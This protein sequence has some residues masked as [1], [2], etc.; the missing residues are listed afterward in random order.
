MRRFD[1]KRRLC[2]KLATGKIRDICDRPIANVANFRLGHIC[3][4]C[5]RPI[6]NVANAVGRIT[7]KKKASRFR[8]HKIRGAPGI[9][10]HRFELATFPGKAEALTARPM[11]QLHY[12][13]I[14]I[15]T[16]IS[17]NISGHVAARKSPNIAEKLPLGDHPADRWNLG[18]GAAHNRPRNLGSGVARL[19][20]AAGLACSGL[21]SVAAG[22]GCR[23]GM[24]GQPVGRG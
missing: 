5:N 10:G 4:I 21:L 16:K 1:R 8:T 20:W 6:A 13:Q 15:I 18:C 19:S 12:R 14:E 24:V 7:R 11:R 22:Q 23:A 17:K 2:R 9:A 3:N